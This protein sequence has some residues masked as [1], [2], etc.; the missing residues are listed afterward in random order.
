MPQTAHSMSRIPLAKIYAKACTALH[1]YI[2]AWPF[3]SSGVEQIRNLAEEMKGCNDASPE[4]QN[5]VRKTLPTL[6]KDVRIVYA[7]KGEYYHANSQAIFVPYELNETL[8]QAQSLDQKKTASEQLKNEIDFIG[9]SQ[10]MDNN[11]EDKEQNRHVLYQEIKRTTLLY[12]YNR[13]TR[14]IHKLETTINGTKGILQHELNHAINH[15]V[16]HGAYITCIIPFITHAICKIPSLFL[17]S[18]RPTSVLASTLA[19]TAKIWTAGPKAKISDIALCKHVQNYE[20]KADEAIENNKAILEAAF[21]IIK[22]KSLYRDDNVTNPNT[23][24]DLLQRSHPGKVSPE[25]RQKLYSS[26]P[27]LISLN[28]FERETF[29]IDM[30]DKAY[31]LFEE[32]IARGAE[33]IKNIEEGIIE[34]KIPHRN[35]SAAIKQLDHV[36]SDFS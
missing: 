12:E 25:E 2:L 1:W 11:V 30:R 9:N 23:Y 10:L 34:P 8:Q 14:A 3:V 33:R 31:H 35:R 32:R 17:S 15:D 19:A 20:Q 13:K 36:I 16:E 27:T 28:E 24:V 26:I 22:E 7:K 6:P 18:W 4:I 21:D 29:G 5:F